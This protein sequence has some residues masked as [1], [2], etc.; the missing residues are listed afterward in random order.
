MEALLALLRE[1]TDA[2]RAAVT[3]MH[4]GIALG[5]AHD[6]GDRRVADAQELLHATQ[7]LKDV[8]GH[9]SAVVVAAA[10]AGEQALKTS[11]TDDIAAV[12][13]SLE[14]L[15]RDAARQ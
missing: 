12:V 2:S 5:L 7:W 10:N 11:V 8:L 3:M 6:A 15:Q 4:G 13:E 14:A 9:S 1:W